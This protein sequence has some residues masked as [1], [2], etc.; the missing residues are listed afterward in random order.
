[1]AWLTMLKTAPL[2]L[3]NVY[4]REILWLPDFAGAELDAFA[5]FLCFSVVFIKFKFMV[6]D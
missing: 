1:M 5:S 3:R 6:G 2:D 4:H